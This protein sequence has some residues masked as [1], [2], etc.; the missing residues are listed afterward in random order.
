MNCQQLKQYWANSLRSEFIYNVD[1]GERPGG[2]T[3]KENKWNGSK[4]VDDELPACSAFPAGTYHFIVE[5]SYWLKE[6]R[7]EIRVYLPF[8]LIVEE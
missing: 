2:T 6:P 7:K 8:D 1:I 3:G 5:L 4:W